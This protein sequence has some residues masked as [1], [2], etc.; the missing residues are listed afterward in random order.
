VVLV[1][2]HVGHGE[3]RQHPFAS[4]K[5]FPREFRVSRQDYYFRYDESIQLYLA[6]QSLMQWMVADLMRGVTLL[7][8]QPGVDENKLIILGAVAGGGDP[9]AVTAAL[10]ERID[11]AVPFNFGGPQPETRYPLPE[12][13]ETSFNYAGSGSWESTR[14]LAWSAYHGY[15]PWVIVGGIAPRKLIFSHEFNWHRERDPVWKRLQKIYELYDVP[16]NLAYTHGRGEL[17]GRPPEATHCT[18]IGPFHRKRIHEAFNKWFG[19]EVE[20]YSKNVS[21]EELQCWNEELRRELKPLLLHEELARRVDALHAAGDDFLLFMKCCA[22]LDQSKP[23]PGNPRVVAAQ[24]LPSGDV[25]VRRLEFPTGPGIRVPV[26]LLMPAPGAER[27]VPVV[28]GLSQSGK[29]AFLEHRASE[30]AEC[31]SKGIAVCLPDVRGTGETAPGSDRGQYSSATSRSATELMLGRTIFD[32][33]LQD[34]LAV[35]RY[36][37]GRKE[38]DGDRMAVWGES[39]ADVNPADVNDRVP[40]RIDGRPAQ[41]E[42]LGGM[43]TLRVAHAK[44]IAAA[45][46]HRGLVSFRSV[47]DAPF[48]YVPHDSATPGFILSGDLA[49]IAQNPRRIPLVF[50]GLVDGLD[51]PVSQNAMDNAYKELRA[52]YEQAQAAKN[53]TLSAETVSPST[54]FAKQ[55]SDAEK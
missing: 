16:G 52:H 5:D 11:C 27:P 13:A 8:Q 32:G 44:G 14:N 39:F 17:K 20:E 47:L 12:D 6:G 45:Y 40:R 21:T 15:L 10:D 26:L 53:L 2:D 24:D 7:T 51:R 18:N 55:L 38:I 23:E 37:G 41:S 30:V 48:V 4:A 1:P 22:R 46:V 36:L 3:R 34:A 29:A 49:G 19:I 35:V 33:R 54:W 50:S 31:L 43:L 28:I 25:T 42:P 9:C